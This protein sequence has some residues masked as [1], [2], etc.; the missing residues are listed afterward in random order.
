MTLNRATKDE[1]TAP[2]GGW[3]WYVVIGCAVN[4]VSYF[5]S[6][7]AILSALRVGTCT[8]YVRFSF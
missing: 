7:T 1:S 5:V 6:N 4:N 2:E 8:K 3:G